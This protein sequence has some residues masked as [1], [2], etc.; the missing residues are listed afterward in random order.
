MSYSGGGIAMV[1]GIIKYANLNTQ[2]FHTTSISNSVTSLK[3]TFYLAST[4]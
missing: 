3:Q 4:Q 2:T 1:S